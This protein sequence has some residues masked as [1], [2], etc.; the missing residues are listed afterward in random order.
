MRYIRIEQALYGEIQGRGH[1]LR[2]ASSSQ[3]FIADIAQK[4]DVPDNIPP[5]VLDWYPFVRGFPLG[6][7]YVLA[8]TFL[9]AQA[10]RGGMVL[11]HALIMRLDEAS[12]LPSLQPLLEHLPSTPQ[13]CGGNLAAFD[14][15]VEAASPDA[16]SNELLGTANA[17]LNAFELPVVRVGVAGF[18]RLV[19][20]LWRNFWPELRRSFAFRLSFGPSDIHEHYPPMLVCTPEQLQ[21]RWPQNRLIRPET[22]TEPSSATAMLGG[23]KDPSEVMAL[24]LQLGCPMRTLQDFIRLERLQSMLAGPVA[25]DTAMAAIRLVDGLSPDPA[26]GSAKKSE[27][28][29]DLITLLPYATVR[30][31]FLMRNLRLTGFVDADLV[32]KALRNVL[33]AFDYPRQ[34]DARLL[35]MMGAASTAEL[36]LPTWQ[37]AVAGGIAGAARGRSP[38]MFK[39]LWRWAEQSASVFT[40]A[41]SML[42]SDRKVE[43][44]LA[45]AIPPSFLPTLKEEALRALAAK[46]WPSAHGALLAA[47][48]KPADAAQRQLSMSPTDLSGLCRAL[49]RASPT[50]IL[51]S[52]VASPHSLLEELCIER[53]LEEQHFLSSLRCESIAEQRVWSAVLTRQMSAWRAPQ[54]PT[55]ARDVVLGQLFAGKPVD[56]RL[57]E[58]FG[59]TPLADLRHVS[60]RERLWGLLPASRLQSYL[61]ATARGWLEDAADGAALVTPDPLLADA[62][63]AADGLTDVLNVQHRPLTR[64]VE[65]IEALHDFPEQRFIVWLE[66]CLTTHRNLSSY[67]ADRIGVLMQSRRWERAARQLADWPGHKR[68]DLLPALRRCASLLGFFRC[69]MLG[70]SNPTTSEKWDSFIYLACELYSQGPDDEDLWSRANGKNSDLSAKSMSGAVRWR[71]AVSLMRSGGG[72][73]PRRLLATM[74]EDYGSNQALRLFSH[75]SDIVGK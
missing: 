22:G 73:S 7:H 3:A 68:A 30:Q 19:D 5:G 23:Q 9:D 43:Q 75:D 13:N 6:D 34:D 15:P 46:A 71:K 1:G 21:A 70:I 72:P 67:D 44:A 53:A 12:A 41:V 18:D 58:A 8:R 62:V 52:L 4:L 61:N 38:A 11:S 69:W 74:L 37:S 39:A 47:T 35:E 10:D 16:S 49:G 59:L 55:A 50:E 54:D 66:H 25:M 57:L 42:P 60:N 51:A 65:I 17:L 2:G 45:D 36:A 28:L 56:P 26:I 20:A 64:C 33:A 40:T 63:L 27:L 14:L 24:A 48:C 29:E 32:W 31:L